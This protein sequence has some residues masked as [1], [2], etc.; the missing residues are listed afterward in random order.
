MPSTFEYPAFIYRQR[1]N[2]GA[3]R[4]CIFHAK[5]SEILQWAAIQRLSKDDPA[6]V[7]REPKPTRILGIKRFFDREPRNTIP[8]A[9]VVTLD[10]MKLRPF[11]IG[12]AGKGQAAND[13]NSLEG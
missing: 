11:N 8:T 2:V 9:V 6:A 7:Q 12:V 10:D 1:S 5:V 3:P 4:F 13:I